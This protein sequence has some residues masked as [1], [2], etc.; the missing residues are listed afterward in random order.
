VK[1]RGLRQNSKSFV[2]VQKLKKN[3][4]PKVTRRSEKKK[5]F[6]PGGKIWRN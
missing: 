4:A 1:E 6:Q 2:V 5:S 3:V